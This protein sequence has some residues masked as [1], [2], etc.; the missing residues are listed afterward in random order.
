MKKII[1]LLLIINVFEGFAA[2][3]TV[4][5]SSDYI[6]TDNCSAVS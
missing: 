2:Q 3:K 1:I 5:N 4:Y 6:I